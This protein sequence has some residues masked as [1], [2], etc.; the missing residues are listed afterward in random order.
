MARQLRIV[1]PGGVY[2]LIARGNERKNIFRDDVDRKMMLKFL[3]IACRKYECHLF[4][5][6]LMSN[7][8]HY[9]VKINAPNL[10]VFMNCVNSG[11]ATY[12]N[13]KYK[14]C[15]HLYQDRFY[16]VLVEHGPEI[17][18][19]VRY[20]HMNPVR[21]G[22]VEKLDEYKWTSHAQ[23]EGGTGVA[24]PEPV[25]KLFS[26]DRVE[27][28]RKYREYMAEAEH[29]DWKKEAIGIYGDHILGSEDF[30]K[31][32]R[33][34]FKEKNLSVDI[35]KRMKLKKVYNPEDVIKSV[36]EFFDMKRDELLFKKSKWNKGKS[37]LMY[38]LSKDCGLNLK[39]I[40]ALLNGLH[41]AGVSKAISK[42]GQKISRFGIEVKAIKKIRQKYEIKNLPEKIYKKEFVR[43][44]F[45]P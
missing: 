8:Y 20:I 44:H 30:V 7:H 42:I 13:R 25:L 10:S 43:Y 32:I 15:G 22:M 24:W 18:R 2:H 23:Y 27:A 26:E 3:D 21:A 16:S 1:M 14:R 6:V 4:A 12:I 19:V 45:K 39:N 9:V 41:Y 36:A 38:L 5:Y 34:M 37:I 31:K 28:I 17:Q 11:Y 33:L 35:S 40:S 29:L